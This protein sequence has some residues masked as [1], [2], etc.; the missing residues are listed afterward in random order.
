MGASRLYEA[1]FAPVILVHRHR[2]GL[3][4]GAKASIR[5]WAA[6]WR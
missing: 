1:G 5:S 3:P 4:G 6:A 2:R